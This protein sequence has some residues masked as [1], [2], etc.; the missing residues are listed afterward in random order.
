MKYQSVMA[1][2][3][4]PPEV[5]Q[6]VENDL[7]P[8]QAGEV[9]IKVLA[10]SVC[11]PDVTVRAGES[12]YSGTPLG[13]KAPF[14]PGYAVVGDI[15]AVGTGV[16][17]AAAGDRVGVLTVVGGY[18]EIL[19]W[20]SDRIIP[21]PASLNP[22]EA[23]TLI[24]NY[25]V[26]YQVMHRSAKVKAGETMLIIGASGGIG[27]ALTQLGKLAGLKM[28][29]IASASKHAALI[30]MGVTPIDYRTQDFVAE[31]RKAEPGGIDVV[32]DGMNRPDYIRGGLSLLRRGGRIV[33]YGEPEGLGVLFRILG[34]LLRVNLLLGDKKFH[35][36]GTSSYFLF[37]RRPY[38]EDWAA[39][40]RLLEEGKIKPVIS[41]VFPL[42]DAI[43]AHQLLENG[44]VIGNL[45][46]AAPE[47]L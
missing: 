7:R 17:G 23:V 42:R 4:G 41:G 10:A 43:K 3:L 11:R 30:E 22:V 35:L 21:I 37:D 6:V 40:C 46:L 36:Y 14:V 15:D 8:P 27:T 2:R 29:G 1:T 9:R 34:I 31:I 12:L 28:Y 26:A 16:T 44:S 45:V 25:L 39:L 47:W 20:R 5:L 13:K 32:I 24:L 19:Y 18:T 33:S 38:I